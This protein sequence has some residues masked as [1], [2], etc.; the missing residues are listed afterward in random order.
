MKAA[1]ISIMAL[2]AA[3]CGASVAADSLR[4][5][6][7]GAYPP[8]NFVNDAG[9]L[10][11]LERE[12]GD[13]LCKRM[14]VECIWVIN[15]WGTII[16]NLVAD[17]YDLIIAGM[18]ITEEREKVIQFTQ[19]YLPP[20]PS[21]FVTL[22]GA[23]EEVVSGVVT[24]QTNTTQ[25]GY[26]MS[27]GATLLEFASADETVDAVRNGEADAVFADKNFLTEMV[28]AS[29]DALVFIGEEVTLGR[30]AGIGVRQSDTELKD[31]VDAVLATM[32]ADGTVNG[33]IKKWLGDAATI[34]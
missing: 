23:S 20:D 10:D 8:F 6:T 24:A 7:E 32:K 3:V 16:P 19:D 34:Y 5:G 26:V 17:N 25:A 2:V 18:S 12:L 21:A 30:G 4:I 9:E 15:D 29:G 11:G 22:A 33:L 14:A 31:K 28:A 1:K 13:E 27:T